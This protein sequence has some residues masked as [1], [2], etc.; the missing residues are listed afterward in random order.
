VGCIANETFTEPNV[1]NRRYFTKILAN[2]DN[3]HLDAK[4][5]AD[6]IT[7]SNLAILPQMHRF[8]ETLTSRL[9]VYLNK[10][11]IAERDYE[12]F[13]SDLRLSE[14]V[15]GLSNHLTKTRLVRL[16]RLRRIQRKH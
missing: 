13:K 12:K 2:F 1:Y 7:G 5:H 9:L 8:L 16:F 11:Y 3:R 15:I 14:L 4:N 10:V 6:S